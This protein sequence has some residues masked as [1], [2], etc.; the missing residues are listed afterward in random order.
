M[1]NRLIK[2]ALQENLFVLYY[3][4]KIN[5]H[6]KKVDSIEALIRI[7][8]GENLIYPEEFIADA[9]KSGDIFDI[10]RWVFNQVIEDSRYISMMTQDDISI[11]LNVSATHF[12]QDSFLENLEDIFDLTTDF[13]SNFELEFTEYSLIEN[14]EDALSKMQKLKEKGFKI[15]IDDFGTGYSS[16]VYLK[17]FPIDSIKIDKSFIDDLEIDEK[18][19]KIVESILFLAKKLDLKVVAEGVEKVNQVQWLFDHGCDEI[20]GYYYSKAVSIDKLVKFIQAVNQPASKNDFIV[21]G[22][23]YSIGNYAFDT[24][25][26][27]I[28]SIL[29]KLYKEL[30]DE[31]MKEKSEVESYFALLNRYIEIHFQAEESYMKEINYK[32]IKAHMKLHQDFK[33]ILEEFKK[34]LSNSNKKNVYELFKILKDWLINHELKVDKLLVKQKK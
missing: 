22:D 21:W 11:A 5:L 7:K 3:Q 34:S 32:D 9:E 28:A 25:H 17:D 2:K 14:K 16:F 6:T 15:A 4:P 33:E 31:S 26:M 1:K 10:D 30:K 29:N 18:T 23:K 19:S 24:H 27:I 12:T 20:Q 13:I 8:D